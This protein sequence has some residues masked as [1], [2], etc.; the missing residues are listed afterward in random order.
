M[1]FVIFIIFIIFSFVL[2]IVV[3]IFVL[4]KAFKTSKDKSVFWNNLGANILTTIIILIAVIGILF[5]FNQNK[6]EQKKGEKEYYREIIIKEKVY[7]E[8]YINHVP[9]KRDLDIIV[10][11]YKT[12]ETIEPKEIQINLD[13]KYR[14]EKGLPSDFTLSRTFKNIKLTKIDK[15]TLLWEL[16]NIQEIW[17][18]F[19]DK[20]DGYYSEISVLE[21]PLLIDIEINYNIDIKTEAQ[22]Q[23]Y[24]EIMSDDYKNKGLKINVE[25]NDCKINNVK[26]ENY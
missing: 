2:L 15:K 23:L 13:I 5:S 20:T 25:F 16:K 12:E 11:C 9:N 26:N 3:A 7:W 1:Y 14:N 10:Y 6:T 21:N 18:T 24:P 22:A 19:Y 4:I 8:A 17:E